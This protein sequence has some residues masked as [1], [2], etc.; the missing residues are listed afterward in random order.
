MLDYKPETA[1]NIVATGHSV[2]VNFNPGSTIRGAHLAN[3]YSLA[4]FHLHWGSD[5]GAGE[6]LTKMI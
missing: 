2:Q 1:E 4:Q 6:S 3:E 5:A